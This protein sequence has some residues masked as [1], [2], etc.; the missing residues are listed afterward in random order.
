VSKS[1]RQ[2]PVVVNL[3]GNNVHG[4]A[5]DPYTARAPPLL[6]RGVV[7]DGGGNNVHGAA[8]N[9]YTRAP[10]ILL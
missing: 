6:H 2:H 8:A 5:V 3:G 7:V 1:Y 9:D 10:Q 4:T